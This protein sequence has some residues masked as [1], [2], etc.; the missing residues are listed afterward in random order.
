M[1]CQGMVTRHTSFTRV[2]T[3]WCGKGNI[4]KSPDDFGTLKDLDMCCMK[5]DSCPMTIGPGQEKYGIKNNGMY[6]M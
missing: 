6:Y 1:H 5:H 4:A 2:G 3:K